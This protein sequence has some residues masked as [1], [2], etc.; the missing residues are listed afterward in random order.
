[1]NIF[2]DYKIFFSQSYGG[3]S[4]YFI[5]LVNSINKKNK[6]NFHA[7][8]F[9]PLYV[10]KELDNNYKYLKKFGIYVPSIFN[11][12]QILEWMNK[13]ICSYFLNSK[14]FNIYHTTYY[15][16]PIVTKKKIPIVV[17]VFD[18]IHEIYQKKYYQNISFYHKK[19]NLLSIA[20]HIVCISKNTQN[21]LINFYNI[22]PKKTSVIYLSGCKNKFLIT[23]NLIFNKPFF[24]YVGNRYRYKNFGTL[25]KSYSL[26]EK[27]FNN[28]DI[29][30]WG[31]GIFTKTEKLLIRELKIPESNV[32]NFQGSNTVLRE[33]Y[34]KAYALVY[35]SLYEGF[36]L[37]VL[38]SMSFGCPVISSNSSSLPEVYGD[39]AISFNPESEYELYESMLKLSADS[40]LRGDLIKKGIKR[41][42]L[43]SWDET[44]SKTIEVYNKFV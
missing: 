32:K 19:K 40:N 38:D 17:T 23:S 37:P 2:F 1:M 28:F 20:D 25:L 3:P 22:D 27:L 44:A 26:S 43:F 42:N 6:L 12:F 18:L 31:G 15:G 41:S 39:A 4:F 30:C 36:G 5:N 16:E 14:N 33:L 29:V 21:D 9:S 35:P 7:K 24:L 13:K 8:I 11:N 34:D 10:N